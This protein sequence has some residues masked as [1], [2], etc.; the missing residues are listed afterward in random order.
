VRR[1]LVLSLLGLL[2]TTPASAARPLSLDG[3]V[4]GHHDCDQLLPDPATLAPLAEPL[5]Q[6]DLD[7]L[8]L[9]ERQ[10]LPVAR[11]LAAG[12]A[13]TYAPLGIRLVPRFRVAKPVPD[14]DEDSEA[15]VGWLKE[16]LG[17]TRPKGVDVVYLATHRPMGAAGQADCIGG[18][19]HPD[20]AF[21]V[22]M[23]TFDGAAGVSVTGT[24]VPLPEPPLAD[25]GAKLMAHELGH[26]LGAHHHYGAHCVLAADAADPAHPCDVMFTVPQALLGKDF[27]PLNA[28]VVRD[29]AER[30]ARP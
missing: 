13:R 23:L 11:Q 5:P 30:F 24:G 12:A 6:V 22:G 29:Q 9:A 2:L 10:D 26:L 8:V 20:H 3:D 21:A 25:G 28:S 16:Q 27:G 15:Y 14:L 7:V 1:L 19:A 4:V 18:I 17:G